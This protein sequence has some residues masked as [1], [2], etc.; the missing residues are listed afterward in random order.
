MML[1]V[2]ICLTVTLAFARADDKK[3]IDI[4][5]AQ[6]WTD[7][8]IDLKAGDT[9][10][11]AATGT[12]QFSGAKPCGPEGLPRG[13]MDLVTQLPLNEAGRGALLGRISD[14]PAARPFLIGP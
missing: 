14:S 4:S 1:R 13:W 2:L 5:A 8:G 6:V 9:I 7:S 11:V 12:L 10:T 3:E